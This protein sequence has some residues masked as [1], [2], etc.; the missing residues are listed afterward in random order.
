MK[1][2]TAR[3]SYVFAKMEDAVHIYFTAYPKRRVLSLQSGL[4]LQS[5]PTVSLAYWRSYQVVIWRKHTLMA[6]KWALDPMFMYDS[7]CGA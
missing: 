1:R 4:S 2:F 7:V 3:R 6:C 5:D